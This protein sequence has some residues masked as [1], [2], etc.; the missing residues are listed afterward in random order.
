MS[1]R[2]LK[3]YVTTSGKKVS[4]KSYLTGREMEA[5]NLALV[6]DRTAEVGEDGEKPKLPLSAGMAYHKAILTNAIVSI[7]DVVEN[8]MEIALD[9]P[10]DEYEALKKHILEELKINLGKTK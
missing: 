3:E 2:E 8:P 1:N 9:L 10:N 7:D 4:F 5:V 6:G